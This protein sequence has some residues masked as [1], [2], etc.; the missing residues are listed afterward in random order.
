M[1]EGD[2][3]A[4]PKPKKHL[5]DLFRKTKALPSIYWMPKQQKEVKS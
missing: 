4:S 5:D 1:A 2:K 3:S